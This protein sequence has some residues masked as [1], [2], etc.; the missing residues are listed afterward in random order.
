LSA[1]QSLGRWLRWLLV[2][3]LAAGLV[4]GCQGS[5]PEVT[6]APPADPVSL[7]GTGASFPLIF[8]TK[9][10]SEYNRLHPTVQINYQ[11]TGS[12]AGIQQMVAATVDFA[13]SDVAMTDEEIAQAAQGIVLVPMTAG[14]VAVAYNLPDLEGDLRLSREALVGI[15]AGEISNWSDPA[16]A[17][18]NPEATLPDLPILVVHR[19]D[20]SGSTAAFTAHLSA[21]SPPWEAAVGAGLNVNW[22]VGVGIKSTAGVSAQILQEAGAIGYVEYSYAKRLGMATAAL[23]NQGG[24][25]IQPSPDSVR[26]ALSEADIPAD[27]RIF[28]PDPSTP[29]AYPIVTYSWLLLYETYDDPAKAEA[30]KAVV[31]WGLTEGQSFSA[32]LGYAPLSPAVVEGAIAALDRVQP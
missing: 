15:F 27:L 30:L 10:F 5:S 21:L 19:S 12:A 26:A 28:V 13:G 11:D 31:Q 1:V 32:D 24:N 3:A 8:Y 7:V 4:I 18:T 25:F 2:V 16:I 9:L 23:E 22:P 17:V 29:A 14:S 6:T 20:G